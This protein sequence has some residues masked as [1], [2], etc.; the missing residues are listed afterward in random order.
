MLELIIGRAGA[1]KTTRI[2]N[3]ISES[4]RLGAGGS[5][6]LVPEQ[7]SHEAERELCGA[8]G[9]AMSLYAEVTSFTGLARRVEA[10]L[11]TGGRVPLDAGGRLLCMALAL[12]AVGTR[13]RL[14]GA[15][16]RSPEM[17]K[18]LLGA[19]DELKSAKVTPDR[20]LA[21]SDGCGGSLSAKL[22][23]LAL[24][25]GAYGAAAGAGRS[26]PADR[27]TILL[28][29][30]PRSGFGR[31]GHLY[32]DG[33]TD[34]TAQESELVSELM[35]RGANLT[36][37]L[38]C[39]SLSGGSEI[40]ELSRR[41]ARALLRRAE[42]RGVASRVTMLES[43]QAAPTD[44]FAEHL[45]TYTD[46]KYAGTGD[47]V[48]LWR[49]ETVTAECEFAAA[50]AIRLVRDGGCRWRD[51]AVTVRG[52]ED[53]RPALEA[54]FAYYGVPLFTARKSDILAKP[55]PALIASAF[56]ILTGGWEPDDVFAYLRTGLAGLT[57]DECDILE[58]Y[59]LLWNVRAGM[60]LS[61]RDWR[62]HPDGY[63]ELN[64][65]S[66]QS[67][68]LEINRLRRAASGPLLRLAE[69]SKAAA[70][71]SGRPRRWPRFS[72][73]SVSPG[74]SPNGRTASRRTAGG[75]PPPNTPGSGTS[76]SPR[77]NSSQGSSA[78]PKW[79]RIPSGGSSC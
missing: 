12:D 36:V 50:R 3:E 9:D 64:D 63:G 20:L 44:F 2:M 15:A 43:G 53:Y 25:L 26:D 69:R 33:F 31:S 7:Y 35:T 57:A 27:L 74:G 49:A 32:I 5:I 16:R 58:N 77:W 13:L 34:F 21:A 65:D 59:C 39:D 51:I 73:T 30:L 40:F 56:E 41:T 67:R 76:S 71:A 37:C 52:F 46:E 75:R 62:L 68:L 47:A 24:I 38:T 78:T 23:D 29:N 72:K 18:A 45:F 10:E 61:G 11:G 19:L 22:S 17:Q 14:Y 55:L 79:I 8:V 42:A 66:A 6:L 1:G 4:A 48:S 70:T 60:W 54:A 28:Q